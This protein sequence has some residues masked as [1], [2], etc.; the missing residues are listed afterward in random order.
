[1]PYSAFYAGLI[2]AVADARLRLYLYHIPQFSGVPVSP[3]VVDR[4]AHGY[5]G[6]VAGVKDSAAD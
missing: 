3:A 4:L 5:P 1:M 2:D 6:V